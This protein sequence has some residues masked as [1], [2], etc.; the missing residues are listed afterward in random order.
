[1]IGVVSKRTSFQPSR[2]GV[3]VSL[4]GGM[5]DRATRLTGVRSVTSKRA[6]S[7]GSS[8]Q[9]N[10]RRASVACGQMRG[11]EAPQRAGELAHQWLL[12]Q[13]APRATGNHRATSPSGNSER[14]VARRAPRTA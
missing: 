6:L 3:G 2:P 13:D 12:E 7:A 10:A 8:Q 4:V 1:M 14:R 5:L 11:R 9:G